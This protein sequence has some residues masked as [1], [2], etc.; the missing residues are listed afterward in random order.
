MNRAHSLPPAVALGQS[1]PDHLAQD[2]V[3]RKISWR[4]M[5]LILI[6]YICAFLDRINEIG[7]ADQLDGAARLPRMYGEDYAILALLDRAGLVPRTLIG[8][9]ALPGRAPQRVIDRLTKLY[10]HGLI[11]QHSVG[12]RQH[13]RS[14]GKPP[15]RDRGK[16]LWIFR[17]SNNQWL[18]EYVIFSSDFVTPG[19]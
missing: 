3:F 4:V 2:A 8:R 12:I 7:P 11:A 13:T 10:R 16:F 1:P 18:I 6:A 5:P 19:A 15:R 9:A 17:E 14:D